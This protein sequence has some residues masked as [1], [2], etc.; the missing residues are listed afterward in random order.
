MSGGTCTE[1]GG[2]G[3][4]GG[5]GY[6]RLNLIL[7]PISEQR[8]GNQLPAESSS[9]AEKVP[10]PRVQEHCILFE[11]GGGIAKEEGRV[12]GPWES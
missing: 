3:G 1:S 7:N 12:R 6:L 2:L 11:V 10:A 8:G 9:A 5:G 4:R